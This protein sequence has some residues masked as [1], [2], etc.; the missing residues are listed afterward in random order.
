[1]FFS[2]LAIYEV[3]NA[4]KNTHKKYSQQTQYFPSVSLQ[5]HPENSQRHKFNLWVQA[6]ESEVKYLNG[7]YRQGKELLGNWVG[8]LPILFI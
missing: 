6:H 3:N 5:H 7:K 2:L 8:L 1:M 4:T